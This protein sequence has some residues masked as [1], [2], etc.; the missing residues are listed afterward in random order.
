LIGKLAGDDLQRVLLALE[1]A[2]LLVHALHE[3]VE[4]GAHL[5]LDGQ[6]LEESV[7]Q[8]GL[9]ATY[10][11]PEVQTLDRQA[12]L[13]TETTE[14]ADTAWRP[15]P[16]NVVVE[17]LQMLY[18]IF[19]RGIVE[20]IRTLEVRLIAF[21]GRHTGGSRVKQGSILYPPD[22]LMAISAGLPP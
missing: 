7:H 8:I 1:L 13:G 12:A 6:R 9:A 14:Q 21:E 5:A 10:T 20:K 17:P 3:A 4:M 11:A 19:L 16:E 18:G 22:R 15:R 2:Q